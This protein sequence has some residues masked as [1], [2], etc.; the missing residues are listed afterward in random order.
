[1]NFF[2]YGNWVIK[3]EIGLGYF[4]PVLLSLPSIQ[5]TIVVSSLA[6]RNLKRSNTQSATASPEG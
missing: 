3:K 6:Q 2:D 4:L 1:M 5:K